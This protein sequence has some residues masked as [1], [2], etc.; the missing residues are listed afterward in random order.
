MGAGRGS[1]SS[2]I[3]EPVLASVAVS[4]AALNMVPGW[5]SV[6]FSVAAAGET[7]GALLARKILHV[8]KYECAGRAQSAGL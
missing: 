8:S 7:A 1:D 3:A 2:A 6:D 4:V 5:L